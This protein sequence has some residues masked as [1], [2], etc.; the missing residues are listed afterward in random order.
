MSEKELLQLLKE[1]PHNIEYIRSEQQTEK[2]QMF[3][4]K[5]DPELI[6]YMNNPTDKVKEFV[7]STN[8]AAIININ[9]ESLTEDD[10]KIAI[11][12]NPDVLRKWWVVYE[13]QRKVPDSI[14][15]VWLMFLGKKN[16]MTFLY[17]KRNG[18]I[19]LIPLSIQCGLVFFLKTSA[20]EY[21]PNFQI[22]N[23]IPSHL[24]AKISSDAQKGIFHEK[25]VQALLKLYED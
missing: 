14:W 8:P 12:H 2:I 18:T 17:L 25:Y 13:D 10:W 7:L 21:L 11:M 9:A 1:N 24:I 5:I 19:D 3:C 15:G 6:L 20:E 4:V 23:K 22:L 16:P